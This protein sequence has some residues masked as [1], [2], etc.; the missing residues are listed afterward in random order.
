MSSNDASRKVWWKLLAGKQWIVDV[1]P[2]G[3]FDSAERERLSD[4]IAE[5]K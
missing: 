3:Y 2:C 5:E 1:D 4:L